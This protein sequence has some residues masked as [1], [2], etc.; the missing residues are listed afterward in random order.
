MTT[1]FGE[2]SPSSGG[3]SGKLSRLTVARK[4]A[5]IAALAVV[6]G[7]GAMVT[8]S[9]GNQ[10]ATLFAHGQ[11]TYLRMTELLA[12]NVAGGLRWKKSDAV[13]KAYIDFATAEGSAVASIMTFAKDGQVLTEFE[14]SIEVPFDLTEAFGDGVSVGTIESPETLQTPG[15]FVIAMPAGRDK[16]GNSFGTLIVAWSLAALEKEVSA[17][18]MQQLI[19]AL[20]ALGLV[21]VTVAFVMS[22][23]VGK[24]LALVTDAMGALANGDISVEIPATGRQDDIGAIARA[25][26][27]FKQNAIDKEALQKDQEEAENRASAQEARAAE[28]KAD[29]ERRAA[30]EKAELE[31]RAAAERAEQERQAATEKQRALMTLADDLEASVKKVVEVVASAANQLQ[32]SA[33]SML[34]NIEQTS[35]Q[36]TTVAAASEEATSSV[37]VVASAA[38][39][40]SSS[41]QEISRQVVQS[42]EIMGEVVETAE[43]TNETV[44][45]LAEMGQKVG[46][47]N[48]LALNATIEAARAGEMGKG[49]AVV[50]NE[51]KSLANQ[52]AKATEEIAS[53]IEGMQDVTQNTV[54]AIEEIR[55][56]IGRMGEIATAIASA[57][58]EQSAS[59]QEIA[60]NAQQAA[61]GT[62]SVSNT[63]SDVQAGTKSTG[64]AAS[65]V[66]E[67][68]SDLS[69]QAEALDGKVDGFLKKIRTA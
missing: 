15:H 44:Q 62:Q 19:V 37:Q 35:E 38:E 33:R 27:V 53:Q 28:E 3:G 30:E 63:I 2:N 64:A 50:A 68:T 36:S 49:F 18:L 58:E 17:A 51:V 39:E 43:R 31:Q 56:V 13:E 26:Q 25:V 57:V 45:S 59:T 4:V 10:R 48:L 52:T 66:A 67:A 60:R 22:K 40:L 7:I 24:P 16:D 32:S 46:A 55:K 5:L 11:A 69:K 34:T 41:I 1:G 6:V 42:T 61:E 8:I 54:G 14:S 29:H 21:V 23:L 12:D 20:V 65:Q 9:I 47:V